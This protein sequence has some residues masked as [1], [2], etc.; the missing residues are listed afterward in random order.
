MRNQKNL[1]IASGLTWRWRL[2]FTVIA[3]GANIF[4]TVYL[5]VKTFIFPAGFG[6]GRQFGQVHALGTGIHSPAWVKG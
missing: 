1:N 2:V 6:T 4:F 5:A 3:F